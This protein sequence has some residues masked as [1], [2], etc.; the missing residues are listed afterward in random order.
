[1]KIRDFLICARQSFRSSGGYGQE[2]YIL[3]HLEFSK[4]EKAYSLIT[5]MQERMCIACYH[6]EE[7]SIKGYKMDG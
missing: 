3:G 7:C 1:M 6:I 5:T 2:L 4:R